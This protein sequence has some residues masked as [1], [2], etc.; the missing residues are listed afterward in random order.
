M[1]ND[2]LREDDCKFEVPA[3]MHLLVAVCTGYCSFMSIF[4]VLAQTKILM[5]SCRTFPFLSLSY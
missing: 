2:A 4:N 5:F 1:G 3:W